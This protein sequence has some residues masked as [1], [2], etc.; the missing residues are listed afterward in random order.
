[1]TLTKYIVTGELDFKNIQV[2][3]DTL[4]TLPEDS[5]ILVK[6]RK[7]I[8]SLIIK[9]VRSKGLGLKIYDGSY[10]NNGYVYHMS[11]MFKTSPTCLL[12][13]RTDTNLEKQFN[14]FHSNMIQTAK[15]NDIPICVSSEDTLGMVCHQCNCIFPAQDQI[16]NRYCSDECSLKKYTIEPPHKEINLQDM[17]GNTEEEKKEWLDK[18]TT[19][20]LQEDMKKRRVKKKIQKN[21]ILQ[22]NDQGGVDILVEYHKGHLCNAVLK[23]GNPCKNPAVYNGY[24]GIRSH[25]PSELQDALGSKQKR[26]NAFKKIMN[27]VNNLKVKQN[28]LDID[29]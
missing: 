5:L 22:D 10:V 21:I 24:C 23:S 7:G 12:I 14:P 9:V 8:D 6:S 25:L 2:I 17:D 20:L 16:Y 19:R 28:E 1:M 15:N 29:V 26:G 18:Y 13:F 4:S 27:Q 3:D 11:D